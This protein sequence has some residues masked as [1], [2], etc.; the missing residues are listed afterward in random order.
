M[1]SNA[2]YLYKNVLSYLT[3]LLC[4]KNYVLS[5]QVLVVSLLKLAVVHV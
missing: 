3:M 5:N 2:I 4:I 1:N